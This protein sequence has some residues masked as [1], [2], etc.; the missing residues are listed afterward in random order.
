MLA[1]RDTIS[2]KATFVAL[3][4]SHSLGP[5]KVDRSNS[6]LLSGD[7]FRLEWIA[8]HHHM[9][10][11]KVDGSFDGHLGR[12]LFGAV[13]GGKGGICCTIRGRHR[14]LALERDFE[15]GDG[16]GGARSIGRLHVVQRPSAVDHIVEVFGLHL[17]LMVAGQLWNHR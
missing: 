17:L 12:Q 3:L 7:G 10:F 8:G 13:V 16:D 11:R 6:Q 1:T 2:M 4:L 14:S 15:A 5:N 9:L